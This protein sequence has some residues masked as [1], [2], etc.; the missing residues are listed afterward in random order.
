ML[1]HSQ[2]SSATLQI[3]N[4]HWLPS[5]TR[6]TLAVGLIWKH[7]HLVQMASSILITDPPLSIGYLLSWFVIGTGW[8]IGPAL[9]HVCFYSE[10]QSSGWLRC[11]CAVIHNHHRSKTE[12]KQRKCS[13]VGSVDVK[14]DKW[15]QKR[16]W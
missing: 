10:R 4:L 16:R 8:E 3:L 14:K 5:F 7:S 11:I 9:L 6:Q 13:R 1:T 2:T 15:P 12:K